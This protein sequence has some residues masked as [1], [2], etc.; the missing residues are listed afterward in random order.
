[1][2]RNVP[3]ETVEELKKKYEPMSQWKIARMEERLQKLDFDES[4]EI[5]AW[6]QSM[7][8]K[9]KTHYIFIITFI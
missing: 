8:S 3:L 5:F 1:M 9:I 7:W 2:D 6:L 4:L